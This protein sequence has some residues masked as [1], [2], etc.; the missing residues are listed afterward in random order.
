MQLT[1][2]KNSRR[3]AELDALRGIAAIAVLI[4]HYLHRYAGISHS[5]AAVRIEWANYGQFGV[6]L[7][8]II[9]G[10]VIFWT[11]S[12]T[13]RP[14]DFIVSRISRLY[15]SY[16]AA[17]VLTFSIVAYFGLEGRQFGG[18]TFIANLTM[19][20]QYLG[21]ALVDGV[22]W[23]LTVELTFYTWIFLLYLVKQ[24]P[25]AEILLTIWVVFSAITKYLDILVPDILSMLIMYEH[26]GF[27]VLG[28]CLYKIIYGYDDKK[29]YFAAF[30]CL[31]AMFVHYPLEHALFLLSFPFTLFLLLKFRPKF[32]NT[33]ILLF[34]G[35]ISYEL[36]LIH[37]NIGYVIL[38]E[39]SSHGMPQWAGTLVAIIVSVT[40]AWALNKFVG[41]PARLLIRKRHKMFVT[42][43]IQSSS[44]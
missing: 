22:Y 34:L 8:F 32:A 4:Y 19:I 15:P 17:V 18:Y 35:T 3:V 12:N 21:F 28:I 14:S 24:L 5:D 7:F 40:I 2:S 26:L 6:Q 37:Q 9:S 38:N 29:T 25:K 20:Q 11:L 16:W 10:F 13:S 41:V 31:G 39:T 1:N 36:Y 33:S 43:M 27:F 23:T 42:R 44:R 30:T